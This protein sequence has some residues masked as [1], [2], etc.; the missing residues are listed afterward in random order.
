MTAEESADRARRWYVL[1][2]RPNCLH[3]ALRNLA[4]QGFETFNPTHTITTRRGNRFQSRSDQLFPGY[5]FVSLDPNGA[6]WPKVDHTYGVARLV[7][8]GGRPAPVP[9]R[10]MHELRLRCDQHDVLVPPGDLAQG[11]RV[12]LASGP[13]ANF[14]TSIE[15]IERGRRIWVLLDFLGRETRVALK[16]SVLE[17]L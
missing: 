15:S 9:P 12:R 1:Q 3:I 14:I 5:L 16:R 2:L 10:L 7:M 11:D 17:R 4:R 6:A 8:F 13:F